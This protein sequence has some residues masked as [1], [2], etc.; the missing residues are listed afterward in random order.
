MTARE[1]LGPR[2][3]SPRSLRPNSSGGAVDRPGLDAGQLDHI[4][5]E[6]I[7]PVG[8]FVDDFKKFAPRFV[9]ERDLGLVQSVVTAAL[10]EVSGVRR[11]CV[12]A[13]SKADFNRSLCSNTSACRA[14]SAAALYSSYKRS[15]SRL[16]FGLFGAPFGPRRQRAGGQRGDQKRRQRDP[17]LRIGDDKSMNRR[18]KEKVETYNAQRPRCERRA[19]AQPVAANNTTSKSASAT[20]VENSNVRGGSAAVTAATPQTAKT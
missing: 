15:I 2:A 11:S 8:L 19:D 16:P 4:F 13:S 20:V 7:K 17:V 9:V 6:V 5:D 18:E 14:R 10:T 3:P 1:R 12:T